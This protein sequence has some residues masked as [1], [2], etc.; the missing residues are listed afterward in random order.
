MVDALDL[1]KEDPRLRARYGIGDM[2]PC[3]DGPPCCMDHFLMARRLVE[4]GVRVVTI[5]FGRWD[6][7]SRNFPQSRGRLPKLDVG[8]SALIEDLHDRGLENDVT[9][10]AWGEFGRTPRINAQG[11]RDHWAPVSNALISGGGLK[12]GQVIGSTEPP[13]RSPPG[14]P[15][16]GPGSLR[17]PLPRPRHRPGD[18]LRQRGRQA[19]AAGGRG[20]ADRGTCLNIFY[21]FRLYGC[22][23]ILFA[24][25]NAALS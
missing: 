15:R 19:A 16:E 13:G 20:E 8:L 3:D 17:H 9:V 23:L 25:A 22:P 7:H 6:F 1:T 12:M 21:L 5:G 11:G 14:P 4:A 24:R 2:E 10:I 18:E